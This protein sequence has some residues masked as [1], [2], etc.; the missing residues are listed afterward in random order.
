MY[1]N[2]RS[3][4]SYTEPTIDYE[5]RKVWNNATVQPVAKSVLQIEKVAM[6]IAIIIDDCCCRC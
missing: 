2:E 3:E 6:Q 5:L 1:I 4:C